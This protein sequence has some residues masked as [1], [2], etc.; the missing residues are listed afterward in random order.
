[1]P[2]AGGCGGRQKVRLPFGAPSQTLTSCLNRPRGE[3]LGT[4]TA[5]MLC[6]AGQVSEP[7]WALKQKLRLSPMNL[8]TCVRVQGLE[9]QRCSE[10]VTRPPGE[11]WIKGLKAVVLLV[12]GP[13]TAV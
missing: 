10:K 12:E 7:L 1:M 2:T 6:D 5:Q 11:L 8:N 9:G 4:L 3:C 13:R